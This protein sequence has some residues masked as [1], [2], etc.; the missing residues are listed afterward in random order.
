MLVEL[1][2]GYE[3]RFDVTE[4]NYIPSIIFASRPDLT[5]VNLRQVRGDEMMIPVYIVV[6]PPLTIRLKFGIYL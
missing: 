4:S 1:N 3:K 6:L 5:E 2:G